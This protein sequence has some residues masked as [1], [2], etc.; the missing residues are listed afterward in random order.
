MKPILVLALLAALASPGQA[1]TLLTFEGLQNLEPVQN[2][3]NGGAGG[4][5]SVGPNLGIV[6]N[7][8]ALAIIDADAGG[9]GNFGGEP[10]PDTALFF[11]SG[12]AILNYAAGFDTGFSFY[13]SAINQ[14]GSINVYDGI[15]GTGNLLAS[16]NLP[17]T[18][19][20]GGPDP[21]GQ[22]SPFLP[23]GV[24]FNGIARSI[25]FG[26]TVNQIAFD[27]ITFGSAT[28]SNGEVP[29]PATWTMVAGGVLAL[30]FSRRRR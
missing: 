21:T 19:F 8:N 3:Y 30:L 18:P 2:Y 27:N 20:N 15:D 11:L 13:Y 24:A 9:T 1:V 29:E 26:G 4:F 22:F 23:I 16:L 28:P 12:T 17:T 10:S 7:A 14:P 5:G 6:F 25:D